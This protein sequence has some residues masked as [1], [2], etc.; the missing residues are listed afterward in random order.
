MYSTGN[1][2]QYLIINYNGKE[3]KNIYI[4]THTHIYKYLNHFAEHL[5]HSFVNQL[6]FK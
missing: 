5:K 2:I 3:C 4:Y 6:Y 1:Y